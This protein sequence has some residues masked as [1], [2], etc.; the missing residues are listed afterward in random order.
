MRTEKNRRVVVIRDNMAASLP[1]PHKDYT[2]ETGTVL[3]VK[4]GPI[5]DR[6]LVELDHEGV[7]MWF[8]DT[9]LEET[10]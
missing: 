3:E 6:V 4:R 7:P 10:P 9:E 2:G 1:D 5:L 8:H